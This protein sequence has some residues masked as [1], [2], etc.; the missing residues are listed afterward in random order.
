MYE[1]VSIMT[2][3]PRQACLQQKRRRLALLLMGCLI[4]M[5]QGCATTPPAPT[6]SE[7]ARAQARAAYLVNDYQRTLDIVE[8]QAIAGEAWAQYTLGY[9]YQY[10]LGVAMNRQL[11]KQW[12]EHAA[13]QGYAPAQAALQRISSVASSQEK[14]MNSSSKP[15]SANVKDGAGAAPA[16]VPPQE[17][18]E[19]PHPT[20][21]GLPAAAPT[22]A[23][24][25]TAAVPSPAE[26]SEL[27]VQSSAPPPQ[28]KAQVESTSSVP[29]P[30]A[31]PR[32]NEEPM[33]ITKPPASQAPPARLPAPPRV[34]VSKPANNG[35]KGRDWIAAQDPQHF[36]LQLIG[37]S[38]E[39]EIIR[40]IRKNDIENEASYYSI[41]RN[42][43]PWFVVLYGN[44][45]SRDAARQAI[46]R[47]PPS[48][49]NASP[50]PRSFGEVRTP[51]GL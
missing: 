20:G 51:L 17:K 31:P 26:S 48:L 37:S 33:A 7:T 16:S 27:S 19:S 29:A 35:I 45:S 11:S 21:T 15:L 4:S 47:L 32:T 8:P 5:L 12:I 43:K 46:H 22:I 25:A 38:N 42:G 13:Q 2:V 10:G 9:M 44:F 36:T 23:A 30:P 39:A 50:W 18:P 41:T 24:P 40:F 28:R 14:E 6:P 3:E 49:R 1:I 34:T